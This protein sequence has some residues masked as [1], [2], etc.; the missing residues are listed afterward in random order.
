[1]GLATSQGESS[2]NLAE[3]IKDFRRRILKETGQPGDI[4]S[5]EVALAVF[6]NVELE[7]PKYQKFVADLLFGFLDDEIS[8]PSFG[9][10]KIS[11]GAILWAHR[12][13]GRS[14]LSRGILAQRFVRAYPDLSFE[15]FVSTRDWIFV[16]N[17]RQFE[18]LLAYYAL[19]SFASRIDT[20]QDV[21][22]N[23][24]WGQP[25]V[26][27]LTAEEWWARCYAGLYLVKYAS[28]IEGADGHLQRFRRDEDAE[29]LSVVFGP[30]QR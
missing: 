22:E 25:L 1:L 26:L 10:V 11:P 23:P 24:D 2:V 12:I 16:T 14:R 6:N 27:L 15:V 30:N 9:V 3:E 18:L 29:M 21:K 19:K 8:H 20:G 13:S 5:Y 7:D 4:R 28:R 17:S